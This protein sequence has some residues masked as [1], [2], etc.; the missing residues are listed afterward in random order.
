MIPQLTL[1]NKSVAGGTNYRQSQIPTLNVYFP[2]G[3]YRGTA[4]SLTEERDLLLSLD[5]NMT[6]PEAK[7]TPRQLQK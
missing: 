4:G 2:R 1:R 6:K 3:V 5:T 7:D